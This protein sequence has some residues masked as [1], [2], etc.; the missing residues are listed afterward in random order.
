MKFGSKTGVRT[1][2]NRR[3]VRLKNWKWSKNKSGK[4]KLVL[5]IDADLLLFELLKFIGPER[6]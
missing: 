5:R 3:V 6:S 1:V 2:N 4:S